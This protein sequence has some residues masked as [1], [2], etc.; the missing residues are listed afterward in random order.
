ML[1]HFVWSVCLLLFFLQYVYDHPLEC[2]WEPPE[3]TPHQTIVIPSQTTFPITHW[4]D[5][6]SIITFTC[7]SLSC[8]FVFSSLF[9]KKYNLQTKIYRNSTCLYI[10]AHIHTP[11]HAWE[12]KKKVLTLLQN[13][14]R[15]KNKYDMQKIGKTTRF[16]KINYNTHRILFNFCYIHPIYF[17]IQ[18]L[19]FPKEDE[20]L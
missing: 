4:P 3:G 9:N 19:S 6:S 13:I 5:S 8:F 12:K 15:Q 11:E 10:H 1:S 2:P 18:L 17:C 14:I 16:H 7:V 20:T